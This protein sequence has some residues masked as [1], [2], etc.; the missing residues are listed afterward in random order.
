M[1]PWIAFALAFALLLSDF[2][3][4]QVLAAVFPFLKAE[5]VLTDTQLGTLS[6]V[7]ALTVAVL[8]VPLSV[9][10]DRLGRRR[11]ILAMA[12]PWGLATLGSA[13]AADYGQLLAARVVVGVG[14]A[15]Y[16]TVGLAVVLA[17][18]P[19][20]RRA[21]LSGAGRV[22]GRVAVA[23]QDVVV[24]VQLAQGAVQGR[25]GTVQSDPAVVPQRPAVG[26]PDG[27]QA[28]VV[29]DNQFG[30]LNR[31]VRL[32]AAQQRGDRVLKQVGGAP[33]QASGESH[34]PLAEVQVHREQRRAA[35]AKLGRP[36]TGGHGSHLAQQSTRRVDGTHEELSA[37]T[38]KE[39][40][41][42]PVGHTSRAGGQGVPESRVTLLLTAPA[43]MV[44]AAT[45][46]PFAPRRDRTVPG[47]SRQRSPVVSRHSEAATSS[48]V[49]DRLCIAWAAPAGPSRRPLITLALTTLSTASH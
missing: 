37:P 17:V 28:G 12:G 40:A 25:R 35:R 10:G 29:G 18:F 46:A 26:A 13:L 48:T 32:P 21:T 14:E 22:R 41:G 38:W 42:R 9:L 5:W 49:D 20:H 27:A 24:Q 34:T 4:R 2:M 31:P 11:A 33:V 36:S 30:D 15:A 44:V 19:A 47:A 6:S 7:V 45:P 1:F 43:V 23:C 3:C 39:V 16:G 8:T